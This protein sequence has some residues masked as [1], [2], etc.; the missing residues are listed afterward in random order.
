MRNRRKRG[1]NAGVLFESLEERRVLSF[2]WSSEEVYL[3]ELVN[4]ARANP[5]AEALRTGVDLEADLSSGELANLVPSEPLALNGP[6]TLASRQHSLDMHQRDFFAHE[7]PDGDRAQQRADANGYDGS[8]GENIAAGYDSVD[9]AHV[10]WLESVGHRKN[11]LSLWETFS[12]TFHYDE[13]GVGFHFPGSGSTYHTYFTQVF[14]FSGTPARTYILGVVYDDGDS[15]D[16]YSIGEGREQVRVDVTAVDS[17]VLVGSYLTDE[18]GN[19]QIEAPA[20]EY[21]VTFVDQATGLG[22][23]ETVTVTH[24][25][26]VKV[27]A[28]GDELVEQLA[29]TDNV[30]AGGATITGSALANG[31]ITVTTLNEGGRPIAFM[32][33][34]GVWTVRDLQTLTGSPTIAGQI[35]TFTD[36][37]DRLTYAAATSA[38]GL[39]LFRRSAEGVWTFRNL[40]EEID[41]S[42]VLVGDV[43]VFV[44]KGNKVHIAGIDSRNDLHLFHQTNQT[45]DGEYEWTSRNLSET[46]LRLD[47]KETPRFVGSLISFVTPWNALNIAGLDQDGNIQAVWFHTSIPRWTV[48]NLSESTG[49]PALTGGLTV[50]LTGWNAINLVGTDADGNVSATWWVPSFGAQWVTSNLSSL[51]SGP[52]LRASSLASFVTSWGAMNIAGL[53]Q[54]GDLVAYWWAPGG[55]W[56]VAN[57][58]AAVP[59]PVLPD[60]RLSGLTVPATGTINIFGASDDGEVLRYWWRP[61]GSWALQNLTDLT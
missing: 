8:A 38:E 2:S 26:N 47:G 19:Y 34:D 30:A 23:R 41:R 12:S 45:D 20:G 53:N 9:E 4:R 3:V 50:Y 40:T 52:A 46:D 1:G 59:E 42:G 55:D 54:D 60:G 36:P 48:S 35:Q 27:D 22:K 39:L 56:S 18:A 33:E 7:N 21:Y 29:P 24:N 6:L 49:A 51:F 13:I 16:F 17:G 61:G 14:G 25:V 31:Q 11:V 15:D 28:T 37:R 5:Q 58:S 10:A 57:L 43:T 44:S 32:Q